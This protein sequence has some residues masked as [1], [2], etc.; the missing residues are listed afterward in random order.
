MP[1][2]AVYAVS[3]KMACVSDMSEDKRDMDAGQDEW[4]KLHG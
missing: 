4:C 2:R 1:F 3:A